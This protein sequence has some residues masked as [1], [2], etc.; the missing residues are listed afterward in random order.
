M[1]SLLVLEDEFGLSI[2]INLNNPSFRHTAELA[3]IIAD[4]RPHS[5]PIWKF[6]RQIFSLVALRAIG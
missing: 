2:S 1:I 3:A 6:A 4:R 5:L